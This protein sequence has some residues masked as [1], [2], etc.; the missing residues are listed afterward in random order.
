MGGAIAGPA[1]AAAAGIVGAAAGA[2][3]AGFSSSKKEER[4]MEE[5]AAIRQRQEG[6]AEL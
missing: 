1:G 4:P 5:A 2:F 6:R 3:G